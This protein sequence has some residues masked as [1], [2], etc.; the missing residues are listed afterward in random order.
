MNSILVSGRAG[1]FIRSNLVD[2]F[3]TGRPANL[4]HFRDG[5]FTLTRSD[6]EHFTSD[7]LFNEIFHL[8]SPTSPPRYMLEPKRTISANLVGAMRLLQ[9]PKSGGRISYMSTSEVYGD[10]LVNLQPANYR[11][12]VDCTGPR[13]CYDESKRCTFVHA[14]PVPQ[15]STNRRPDL[16]LARLQLPG[17][18]CAV[19]Y[20][21]RVKRTLRWYHELAQAAVPDYT[22]ANSRQHRTRGY[23]ASEC[24]TMR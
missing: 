15:D 4:E 1:F 20:E 23:E 10:P 13:S 12:C 11:G 21:E 18:S 22:C 3:R 9:L 8:A 19:P 24:G 7:L 5:R 16:T 14:D 6:V 17:W 2:N